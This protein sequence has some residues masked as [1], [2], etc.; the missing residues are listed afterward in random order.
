MKFGYV[1]LALHSWNDELPVF[2]L[3]ESP[4]HLYPNKWYINCRIKIKRIL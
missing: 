1:N 2:I 4:T 3:E